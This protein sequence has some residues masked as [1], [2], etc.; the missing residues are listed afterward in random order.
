MAYWFFAAPVRSGTTG[1]PLAVR[2]EAQLLGYV[3]V[4]WRKAPLAQL[5]SW[6]FG[7]NGSIA[8]VLAVVAEHLDGA[9]V[10]Q[11]HVPG[12]G[13]K[14]LLDDHAVVDHRDLAGMIAVAASAEHHVSQVPRVKVGQQIRTA[15][16]S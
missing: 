16:P 11:D 10:E 9:G 12:L 13:L 4:A 1:S 5:R 14:E 6:L 3:A 7:L 8:L 2:S 15:L